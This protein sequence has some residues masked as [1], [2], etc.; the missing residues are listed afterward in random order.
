MSGLEYQGSLKGVKG[1]LVTFELSD[2]LDIAKVSKGSNNGN[3]V[4]NIAFENKDMLSDDQRKKIFALINDICEHTGYMNEEMY[5]KMKFYF[6][7]YSGCD[8]FSIA[9]NKVTKEFASRFIE[10]IIEWCF[11][12]EIPFMNR[13]YH[14]SSNESRTL[15]IYLK[16]RSCFVCGKQHSDVAHVQAVGSGRNRRKIDHSKHEFMCLCREHHNEQH[17]IGIDTFIRKHHLGVIKLNA[18]QIKEL[19]IGGKTDG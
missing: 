11:Q 12:M 4:A 9:R 17:T 3:I 8:T 15:F 7:A 10:F 6:M 5:Q 13:D 14:L 1:R 18:E 2:E 16:Y 19:K